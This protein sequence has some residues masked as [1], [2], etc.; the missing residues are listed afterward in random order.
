MIYDV[1]VAKGTLKQLPLVALG[2]VIALVVSIEIIRFRP[3]PDR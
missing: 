2:L 1:P 3:T